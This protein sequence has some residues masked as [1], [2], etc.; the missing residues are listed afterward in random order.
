MTRHLDVRRVLQTITATA[1]RLVGA[2]YAALG[3]PDDHGGFAQFVVDGISDKQWKAIGPLPRQHGVL[4]EMVKKAASQRLDDVREHPDFGGWPSAHPELRDFLGVPIFDGG[5]EGGDV[6][7][8]LFLSNKTG[9]DSFDERDEELLR[10]LADHAAI[11]LTNARLY[12]RSRELTIV[13][14][15]SRIAQ[16]LHDAVAQKL[17]SLRLTAQAASALLDRGEPDRAREEL[18]EVA[19]LA[20]QAADELRGVVVELRPAALV[21]DGLV[22]ALRSEVEV[23]DRAHSAH[24]TIEADRLRALP[25]AQEEA[26]LRIAQ[27]ALHNALR[28]S[29][30]A[31]VRVTFTCRGG[32]TCES[33]AVLRIIDDGCGFDVE[34][35]RGKGR[36]LG[37]VSMRERAAA[38]GGTV[39]V[40]SAPGRG[41]VIELEVPG[42]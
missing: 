29:G 1:R 9:A 13:E 27:E 40:D 17:F 3:V 20:A 12:E 31:R 19:S 5:E 38:V 30:A 22:A 25:A 14:E 28:H 34:E 41:T 37:L 42:G 24:V 16:E 35:V 33:G 7:G 32:E 6:L 23:L 21:E 4:A 10:T 11:A 8:A 15:R 2:R 18:A 26:V 39:Q 36:R